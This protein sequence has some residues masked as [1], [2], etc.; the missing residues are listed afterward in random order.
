M[1]TR[2]L[3]VDG[4]PARADRTVLLLRQAGYTATI[5]A[6]QRA[7]MPALR[8]V[9]IDLLLL[10]DTPP[11]YEGRP[12]LAMLREGNP[13]VMVILLS[14]RGSVADAM[15]GLRRGADNYLA[16]PFEPELLLAHIEAA[17]RR[18]R[19]VASSPVLHAG[20]SM[21]DRGALRFTAGHRSAYLTPVE[22][23]LLECLM[24]DADTPIPRTALRE[25]VGNDNDSEHRLDFYIHRL[26]IKIEESPARPV[27]IQS[28]PG[29]GY[30]FRAGPERT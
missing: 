26:R 9:A 14:P 20:D 30:V 21:L 18:K 29:V 28:V 2:I 17:V 25:C 7:V 11:D 5:L 1:V 27:W 13:D 22:A 12:F 23:R 10:I 3:V 15:A 6:D 4:D 24:R 19:P 8:E 16:M